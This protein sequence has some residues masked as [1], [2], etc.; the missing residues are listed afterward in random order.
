MFVFL[1]FAP[2]AAHAAAHPPLILEHLTAAD[3]LPQST[4]MSTLQDSRGFVWLGTEDGLVRYD[5][6]ELKRFANSPR[7]PDS[8]PGQYVWDIAED[9]D[10]DLWIAIKNG[11][12][13]RWHRDTDR[14]TSYRHVAGDADSLGSDNTRTLHVDSLGRVWIGTA[15]AGIDIMDP[16]T[17][18]VRHL[19]H[20]PQDPASLGS[21]DVGTLTA[22]SE[23]DVWIGS[24]A[25]LQRWSAKLS[26][27]V[28]FDNVR[29]IRVM[30]VREDRAGDIWV[31]TLAGGLLRLGSDGTLLSTYRHDPRDPDS[32]S[33][34]QVRALQ[35]DTEGRLWVG[36]ADG[37]DLLD[38]AS[39]EFT[40]YVHDAADP[41]SLRDTYIMSLYQDADGLL[42]IGTRTGGV[43]RWNPR[44]W[45]L[46]MHRPD[47]LGTEPVMGF[48]DGPGGT[49]W[50][51]SL[52]AGL[53]LYDPVRRE[54]VQ[55]SMTRA[56]VLGDARPMSLLKDRAGT[57]WI[58][59]FANGLKSI[60]PDG[61]LRSVPVKEGEHEATSAAGV[62]SLLQGRDGHIWIG[63]FGGGANVLDPASGRIRQL[64]IGGDDGIAGP[65]VTAIAEDRAGN[66]WL[67]TDGYGLTLVR[68]NGTVA[69]V[70]RHDRNDA[71]SLPADS[72]Y[73]LT[74]AADG[75]VWIGMEGG[76]LAR[77][78]G[79]AAQPKSLRFERVGR[80]EGLFDTIYGILPGEP[81]DLWLSGNTG[82]V[83]FSTAQ[84]S[85][86][87]FRREHGLQGDEFSFGAYHR[88]ADGRLAFGGP[89]GFNLFDPVQ[90][91]AK[92]PSPRV[93]LTGLSVMGVPQ[94]GAE[95]PWLTQRFEFGFPRQHRGVRL[96]R[97]RLRGAAR[98]PPRVPHARSHRRVDRRGRTAPHHH[99][100]S[101]RR[102]QRAGSARGDAG[103]GL[104]RGAAAHRSASRPGAMALL[105]RLCGLRIAR[106][107]PDRHARAPAAA[108]AAR[109]GRAAG[110]HREAR[111]FRH[112]HRTREPAALH[113]PHREDAVRGICPGRGRRGRQSRPAR[114]QARKR[115]VRSPARRPGA[116]GVC[117]PTARS[118]R[119]VQARREQRLRGPLRRRRVRGG[120][121][122]AGCQVARA[123]YR[124]GLHG[125]LC[126]AHRAAGS[127]LLR[128]AGRRRC[129]VP[130]RR[131]RR[132]RALQGRR[133]CRIQR[134]H[135]RQR[136]GRAVLRTASQPQ[137]RL[138]RHRDAP[139]PCRAERSAEGGVPAQVPHPRPQARR[140]GSTAAL[141]RR[142]VW[143][144]V[145]RCSSSTSRRA[146]G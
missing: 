89:G 93:V 18:K 101:R 95:P 78:Q 63:T 49:V 33:N 37:L 114:S 84:K 42:W 146:A 141:A 94:A 36:T 28:Q 85:V 132:G 3:G 90:L 113:G 120:A 131:P 40:H 14:F 112:A 1:G 119:G 38:R 77:V 65:N 67:G 96:R 73:A 138:A 88:F 76:G 61:R 7:D 142:Q 79:D 107:T 102:Q 69:A 104:E 109:D 35:E 31:G 44:S 137:A 116:A 122:G 86:R 55:D 6:R 58:G 48:A 126:E 117:R 111:L 128:R 10:G 59:T 12:V 11:G 106:I 8:L 43:S 121:Q 99:H 23:G 115:L 20:D 32:I 27:L 125:G 108:Q 105:V 70:F 46:G 123:A 41:Q 91:D 110:A 57:L 124:P 100:Q 98:Q 30:S 143:R 25:G 80:D 45:L 133:H 82:I 64:P 19:R 39:G 2:L 81:G 60:T 140:R 50:I 72:I 9:R 62:M 118:A 52:Q 74:L 54:R 92:R 75:T 22:G 87:A 135:A 103:L 83:R 13:A 66:I 129:L 68:P 144:R 47:W 34:D 51:A 134:T 4:V 26:R 130:G 29:G 5:G 56:A 21:D 24:E 53:V 127:R 15:D 16:A 136:R 97:A 71:Q 139:A 145:P 17:G